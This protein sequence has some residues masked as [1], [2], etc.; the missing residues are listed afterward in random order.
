RPHR[1]SAAT[2]GDRIDIGFWRFQAG[3]ARPIRT[4][5][6]VR[7]P[8]WAEIA[9]NYARRTA[10][11]LGDLARRGPGSHSR[12]LLLHGP[13][14]TGK[15][16]AIRALAREWRDDC[17]TSVVVDPERLF[18]DADYLHQLLTALSQFFATS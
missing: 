10:D 11:A 15:T 16:T 1:P 7:A 14:G 12:L 6:E 17:A 5:T 2:G 18:G 13:P 8:S 9:D 3:L 4:V